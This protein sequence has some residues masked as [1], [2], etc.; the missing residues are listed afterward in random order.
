MESLQNNIDIPLDKNNEYHANI[1]IIEANPLTPKT[2]G[3]R[4]Q[5]TV[6]IKNIITILANDSK[7]E[8]LQFLFY[9]FCQD[10]DISLT[11]EI[12][13]NLRTFS[14]N[15]IDQIRSDL[16]E[17]LN[18]P[19]QSEAQLQQFCQT[20]ANRWKTNKLPSHPFIPLLNNIAQCIPNSI[21]LVIPQ[22]IQYVNEEMERRQEK[23]S[24]NL[25]YAFSSLSDQELKELTQLAQTKPF[26][27]FKNTI[28]AWENER[29]NELS[30][31]SQP[32]LLQKPR[33]TP[34]NQILKCLK[35]NSLTMEKCLEYLNEVSQTREASKTQNK[36]INELNFK[37]QEQQEFNEEN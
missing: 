8:I 29:L 14:D 23:I 36:D 25:R 18:S 10:L 26:D 24:A 7:K 30:K 27:V 5:V 28:L 15:Q 6:A 1:E 35:N 32:G 3:N 22:F 12:P 4:R 21:S 31:N 11:T 19:E 13:D 2:P 17:L 9:M 37:Q 20:I 16:S 34:F 33:L